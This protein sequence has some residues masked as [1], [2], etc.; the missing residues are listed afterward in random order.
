MSAVTINSHLLYFITGIF[1]LDL[2]FLGGDQSSVH[3][4]RNQKHDRPTLDFYHAK[5]FEFLFETFTLI[6]Y[7]GVELC[8]MTTHRSRGNRTDYGKE[9]YGII[10]RIFAWDN[11]VFY[12][13]ARQ[14]L[15][16]SASMAHQLR[17]ICFFRR[18][19]PSVSSAHGRPSRPLRHQRNTK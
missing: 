6:L 9:C 15:I 2:E 3:A 10:G 12:K 1:Q 13:T 18:V 19:P 5:N 17:R 4:F 11:L 14:Q 16:M 8:R 7:S